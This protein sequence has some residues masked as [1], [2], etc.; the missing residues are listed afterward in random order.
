MEVEQVVV[1]STSRTA[2]RWTC[3]VSL[4]PEEVCRLGW[5]RSKNG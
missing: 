1:G 2:M 3:D 4:Y 5:A